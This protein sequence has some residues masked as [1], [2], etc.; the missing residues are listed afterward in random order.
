[1]AAGDTKLSAPA[2]KFEI[3]KQ[4]IIE[5]QYRI[6]ATNPEAELRKQDTLAIPWADFLDLTTVQ[7][8]NALTSLRGKLRNHVKQ[9]FTKFSDA[10]EE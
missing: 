9:Y 4:V 10:I 8:R 7:E 5:F 3:G 2:V 1:M 6:E